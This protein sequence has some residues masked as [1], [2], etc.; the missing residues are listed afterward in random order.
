MK[1][2]ENGT[3]IVH[4][5]ASSIEETAASSHGAVSAI[6]VI[7]EGSKHQAEAAKQVSIGIDQISSV[8]Q[9]NSATAQESAAAS[10]ELSG[11]AVILKNLVSSFKLKN[12]DSAS[13]SEPEK[14]SYNHDYDDMSSTNYGNEKY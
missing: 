10:E 3:R 14:N 11:Q 8:I 2:V 13:K 12:S 5:T 6:G 7:S 9:T 1:A 4:Q